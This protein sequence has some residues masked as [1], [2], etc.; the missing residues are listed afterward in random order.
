[1]QIRRVS[2]K[3]WSSGEEERGYWWCS[4]GKLPGEKGSDLKRL[5]CASCISEEGK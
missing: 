3:S 2:A 5:E 4:E 1:M